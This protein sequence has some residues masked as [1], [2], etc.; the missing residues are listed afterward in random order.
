MTMEKYCELAEYLCR[1]FGAER[2][3][4]MIAKASDEKIKEMLEDYCI[5]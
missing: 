2:M 4:R 3:V 5:I 1:M